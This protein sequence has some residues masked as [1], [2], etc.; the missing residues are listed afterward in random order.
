[1]FRPWNQNINL[2]FW[3]EALDTGSPDPRSSERRCLS[4]LSGTLSACPTCFF[5][6]RQGASIRANVSRSVGWS[7]HRKKFWQRGEN[8]KSKFFDY[9]WFFDKYQ[10][11]SA[12]GTLSPPAT[13]HRL[14]HL[15]ARFIQN[16]RRGLERG[17]ILSYWVLPS[18]FAK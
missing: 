11:S 15:T 16:G 12:G 13:P 17:P 9:F 7:V 5:K 1:M 2:L 10:P 14:Q 18:T 4:S 3:A 6:L 8:Q